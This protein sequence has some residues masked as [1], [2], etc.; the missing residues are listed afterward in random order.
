MI[1]LDQ[2][3]TN[4]NAYHRAVVDFVRKNCKSRIELFSAP[5]NRKLGYFKARAGSQTGQGKIRSENQLHNRTGDKGRA[6]PQG[7]REPEYHHCIFD[8]A[9]HSDLV[10]RERHVTSRRQL[11]EVSRFLGRV[12]GN[13]GEHNQRAVHNQEPYVI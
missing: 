5:G 1:V 8:L 4:K 6:A 7:H 2:A 3:F 11:G 10:G 13:F 9:R 12:P